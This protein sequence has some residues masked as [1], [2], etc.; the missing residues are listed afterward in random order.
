MF[1]P[2]GAEYVNIHRL[3]IMRWN[4]NTN[5]VFYSYIKLTTRHTRTSH[6]CSLLS[7]WMAPNYI[8]DR[9]LCVGASEIDLLCSEHTIHTFSTY[10]RKIDC[11]IVM[12]RGTFG[13]V[14]ESKQRENGIKCV[15]YANETLCT[16]NRARKWH[17]NRCVG[18][19]ATQYN[20]STRT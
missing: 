4:V 16:V 13:I 8:H 5:F 2:L 19:I 12:V 10:Q 7:V 15:K 20:C 6:S 1:T 3:P 11:T 17:S 9:L 18:I 14:M